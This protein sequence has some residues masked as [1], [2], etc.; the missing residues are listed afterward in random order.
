MNTNP[1]QPSVSD[2]ALRLAPLWYGIGALLL[3]A[4]ALASLLPAPPQVAVGDKVSHLLTYFVLSGW[5]AVLARDAK[6]LLLSALGL[7]VYGGLI[8]LLQ[9]MTGYRYAEWADLAAN[10]IG[11]GAGL[12]CYP[13][14]LRRLLRFIDARLAGLFPR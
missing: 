13:T 10:G 2:H 4:V 1:E 3:A 5:F 9:G 12:L 8:E 14:P 6:I 11:I 7:L